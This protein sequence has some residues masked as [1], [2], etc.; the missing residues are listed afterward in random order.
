MYDPNFLKWRISIARTLSNFFFEKEN[1]CRNYTKIYEYF[2]KFLLGTTYD[3][4]LNYLNSTKYDLSDFKLPS[5]ILATLALLDGMRVTCD[6]LFARKPNHAWSLIEI[7]EE[8][9]V[10]MRE[11]EKKYKA[12]Q[13]I[14]IE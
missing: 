7:V 2:S 3:T 12:P 9:L 6:R 13:K 4:F 11:K 10:V 14:T 5:Y 8:L 1:S